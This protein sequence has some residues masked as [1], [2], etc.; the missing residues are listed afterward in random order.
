MGSLRGSSARTGFGLD[1][2]SLRLLELG[3]VYVFVFLCVFE[4]GLALCVGLLCLFLGCRLTCS[5]ALLLHALA[6]ALCVCV[7]GGLTW[8]AHNSHNVDDDNNNCEI[9]SMK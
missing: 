5:C 9:R 8:V 1:S 7:C 2:G 3:P 4:F 6:L